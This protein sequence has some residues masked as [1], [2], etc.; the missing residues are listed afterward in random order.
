[1]KSFANLPLVRFLGNRAGKRHVATGSLLMLAAT[2]TPSAG[3]A[4]PSDLELTNIDVSVSTPL[5]LRHAG[6]G[7]GRLFVA[8]RAG[9]ILVVPPGGGSESTFLQ[10][11]NVDTFFEGGLLGL[12]FHP[13]YESNGYFY[14]SYTRDGPSGGLPLTTVIERFTVSA[15]DPNVADGSSGV[16]IFTVDQPAGNHNGGDL[17]FGPDGL[18]YLGLGD[19]GANSATAQDNSDLLGAM[20]RIDPCDTTSCSV[21]YTIPPDNPFAQSSGSERDEIWSSGFRN[22]YRWSFDRETGDMFIGDVG[23]SSR[24][25]VSFE[26]ASHPG[27][28]NYGWDCREGNINGP[29]SCSGSFVEPIVAYNRSGGVCAVAGGYRYRGCIQGLVGTYVYADYCTAEIFFATETSP[30]NWSSS[31]WDN[32]P[33]NI[34]GFGEDEAGELYVLQ[35]GVVLRFDSASDCIVSEIFTDG[36]ES[37]ALT[38]WEANP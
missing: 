7:S 8:D 30:G 24:E 21:P 18:L 29:G 19:G 22:P 9:T 12:A 34:Y 5:A 3:G 26:A 23:E 4:Q 11:G 2:F 17:H 27:G 31:E 15:M 33:G 13:S 32:L 20:I 35:D 25:E 37:G 6:D 28:A 14:V 38:R 16:V 10:L 1:M 36:F